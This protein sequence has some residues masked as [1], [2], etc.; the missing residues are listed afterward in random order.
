MPRGPRL[1]VPGTL[2]HAI[3]RG[4]EGNRI[5][6]DDQDRAWLV[7][8]MA[9][10]ASVSDT[11]IYAWAIMDNHVHL[12]LK[13]GPHGLSS[14]MRKLLTSY[15][16]TYN[17]RHKRHGYLF[18]N[19]F[20]SIIC[21]EEIYFRKL[22]SYI[23]LNPLRAGLTKSLKE[24][25][26]FPWSGHSALMGNHP[27][28]WQQCEKVLSYF[29]TER[30]TGRAAYRQ[31][32]EDQSTFGHQPE[33]TGGGLKRSEGGWAEIKSARPC[34][35]GR[36]IEKLVLGDEDFVKKMVDQTDDRLKSRLDPKRNLSLGKSEVERVC[37]ENNISVLRL[38]SGERTRMMSTMRKKLVKL[39]VITHGLSL[40][41]T[42][43]L[44][45]IST[46]AVF[47][48][49]KEMGLR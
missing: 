48:L 9:S 3:F 37:L 35:Q 14:Y 1:D 38:H 8:K 4:I 6:S 12:L 26:H 11:E 39:L 29:G 16:I 33:L 13:S 47:M 27:N 5:V 20:K 32:I 18:Q 28:E 7:D 34:H 44:L 15:A 46:P 49:L 45:G 10:L 36:N 43:R 21:Q 30:L 2:H 42:A 41:E 31:F 17:K 22:V 23:H 19:R 40:A 25:D 24:L